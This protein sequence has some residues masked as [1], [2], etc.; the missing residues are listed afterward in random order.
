MSE[1]NHRLFRLRFLRGV[2]VVCALI[3]ACAAARAVTLEEVAAVYAKQLELLQPYR[4]RYK[5]TITWPQDDGTDKVNTRV[6]ELLVDKL[7]Y[8]ESIWTESGPEGQLV[9]D[10]TVTDN[11]TERRHIS[12]GGRGI[13]QIMSPYSAQGIHLDM[14]WT[15]LA[16]AGLLDSSVFEAQGDRSLVAGPSDIRA[17]ALKPDSALLANPETL[18]GKQAYVLEWP[19]SKQH[20][21][22]RLWL[23]ADEK[24][25]LLKG[26][27][28][29]PNAKGEYLLRSRTINRDFSEV[30]P[31]LF[32]PTQSEIQFPGIEAPPSTHQYEF[33]SIDIAVPVTD[34]DFLLEFSDGMLVNRRFT[35]GEKDLFIENW[36]YEKLRILVGV[37]LLIMAGTVG[38]VVYRSLRKVR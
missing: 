27:L 29:L 19:K 23:S 9:P 34:Q 35:W 32:L 11:G 8:K 24:L 10:S 15:P 20:P 5:E 21:K 16:L 2:V 25:S 37:C 33:V 12:H 28:Y 3:L 30:R 26:E 13:G 36:I 1:G 7:R 4:L 18:D 31:G 6:V 14:I 17:L 38:F 22:V